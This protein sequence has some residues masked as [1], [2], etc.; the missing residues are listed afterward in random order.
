MVTKGYFVYG[1]NISNIKSIKLVHHH[2]IF[3][4]DEDLINLFCTKINKNTIYVPFNIEK[5]YYH[6]KPDSYIGSLNKNLCSGTVILKIEF[7]D[8]E[9]ID[10]D[11]VSLGLM[12]FNYNKLKNEFTFTETFCCYPITSNYC[13]DKSFENDSIN[14][15]F[16][17]IYYKK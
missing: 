6:M 2:V 15:D 16:N 11:V 4:Y 8:N 10:C 3:I 17:K 7:Y 14:D 13:T 9:N 12:F 1:K 5:K